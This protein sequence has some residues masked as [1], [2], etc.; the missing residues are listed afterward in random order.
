MYQD[1]QLGAT[2]SSFYFAMIAEFLEIL[3]SLK[4]AFHGGLS[5]YYTINRC[6]LML[7]TEMSGQDDEARN[8]KFNIRYT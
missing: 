3:N 6:Y 2:A 8:S 4:A 5:S 1:H 7:G